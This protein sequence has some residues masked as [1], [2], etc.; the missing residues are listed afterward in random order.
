MYNLFDITTIN[1]LVAGVLAHPMAMA[2]ATT[3]KKNLSK[4][5]YTVGPPR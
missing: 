2:V 3:G 4:G 5:Y 1:Q